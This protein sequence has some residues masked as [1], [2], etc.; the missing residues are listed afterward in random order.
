M[1][2]ITQ[3]SKRQKVN[4]ETNETQVI[5]EFQFFDYVFR[6]MLPPVIVKIVWDYYDR[7]EFENNLL[8]FRNWGDS[9]FMHGMNRFLFDAWAGKETKMVTFLHGLVRRDIRDVTEELDIFM[10]KQDVCIRKMREEN[11]LCQK[12]DA[13]LK[14]QQQETVPP[15][16]ILQTL[17]VKQLKEITRSLPVSGQGRKQEIIDSLYSFRDAVQSPDHFFNF[18]E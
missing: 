12:R 2:T 4:S 9:D 17:T 14:R 13:A 1:N 10:K 6:D 5:N 15:R 16:A 3:K 7:N 18:S 11:L 8:L